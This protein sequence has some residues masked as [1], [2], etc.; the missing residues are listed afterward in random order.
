MADTEASGVSRV[1]DVKWAASLFVLLP[2][3][4]VATGWIGSR[5]EIPLSRIH[6]T[7]SLAEEILLE[8]AGRRT[9]MTDP[10]KA[11]RASGKTTEELYAEATAIRL[12][13]RKGGWLLGGFV[14]LA[15]WFKLFGS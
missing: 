7:V 3:I 1:S 15:L 2:V 6:P 13:I 8:N 10:A 14:G 4:L 11:F 5:L 12:K 9:E